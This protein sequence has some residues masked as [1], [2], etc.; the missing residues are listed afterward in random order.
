MDHSIW[1]ILMM[2]LF[3]AVYRF[4]PPKKINMLYGYRTNR[5]MKTQEIWNESNRFFSMLWF[6]FNLATL[7][8]WIILKSL[9]VT[10]TLVQYLL[11]TNLGGIFIL[12]LFTEIHLRKN[13]DRDGKRK[14]V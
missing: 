6:W 3:S 8:A 2:T 11:F 10:S 14:E 12:I 5:S 13:F 4:F 1:I 7:M 9:N